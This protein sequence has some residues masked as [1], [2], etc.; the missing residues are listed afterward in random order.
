MLVAPSITK[1][2]S[3]NSRVF[4]DVFNRA[5]LV[6]TNASKGDGSKL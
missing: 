4:N 5:T 1:I 3:V 2:V 6:G